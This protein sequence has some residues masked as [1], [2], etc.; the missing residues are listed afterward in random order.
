MEKATE[1]KRF[2]EER[3]RKEERHRIETETP[4]RTKY[5]ES[6]VNSFINK[7]WHLLIFFNLLICKFFFPQMNSRAVWCTWIMWIMKSLFKAQTPKNS[8]IICNLMCCFARILSRSTVVTACASFGCFCSLLWENMKDLKL[9]L[10]LYCFFVPQVEGWVY[11][12]PLWKT[13]SGRSSSPATSQPNPWIHTC[14]SLPQVAVLSLYCP[15][16]VPG[17]VLPL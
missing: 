7:Q 13:V 1:H 9:R 8:K 10:T 6:K 5:F 16:T 12:K 4:W 2:L 3:Q 14:C 15:S 11:H 17:S